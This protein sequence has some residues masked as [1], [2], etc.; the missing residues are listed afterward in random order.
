MCTRIIHIEQ[1]CMCIFSTR[2]EREGAA[3]APRCKKLKKTEAQKDARE[4]CAFLNALDVRIDSIDIRIV[5][6]Y[7]IVIGVHTICVVPRLKRE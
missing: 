7:H 1:M 4:N 5:H 2:N 3:Q 6:S